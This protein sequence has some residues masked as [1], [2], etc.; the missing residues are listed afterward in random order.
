MHRQWKQGQVFWEEYRGAAWLC[1]DGVRKAKAQLNLARDARNSKKGF[2]RYVS[3]K[4]KVNKSIPPLMSKTGKLVTTDEEKAEV[5]NS[6]LPQ[7]SLAVSLPTRLKW[8][9]RKTDWGSEVPPTVREDQVRDHLRNLNIWDLM[10]C[11]PAS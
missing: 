2:Y 4:R 10:T 9:D 7:S 1:R 8:M 3:Q 5:C 6:F 11:I